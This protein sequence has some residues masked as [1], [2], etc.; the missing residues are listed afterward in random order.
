RRSPA[1]LG[2]GVVG[3]PTASATSVVLLKILMKHRWGVE[4]TYRWFDQASEDPFAGGAEAAL[5]IGDIAL[6][7]DLY[8]GIDVRLDLGAEWWAETG[9]PF[10]FAIWQVSVPSRDAE[11]R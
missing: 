6:K 9:L 7:P 10:A 4:P 3:I 8:P 5:F 1:D 2:G 11:L